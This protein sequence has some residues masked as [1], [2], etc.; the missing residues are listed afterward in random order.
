M[1]RTRSSFLPERRETIATSDG[2]LGMRRLL[3]AIRHE[4]GRAQRGVRERRGARRGARRSARVA[5]NST[6]VRAAPHEWVTDPG[7][8]GRVRP[9]TPAAGGWNSVGRDGPLSRALGVSTRRRT[10]AGEYIGGACIGAYVHRPPNADHGGYGSVVVVSAAV[11]VG[12]LAIIWITVW[13]GNAMRGRRS[14]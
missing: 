4:T 9:Y 10:A 11:F 5:I 1:F 14:S 13:L 12:F 6:S 2:Y 7:A 8:E 3:D